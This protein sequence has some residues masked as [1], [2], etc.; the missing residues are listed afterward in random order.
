[1]FLA[2]CAAGCGGGTGA[3][4]SPPARAGGVLDASRVYHLVGSWPLRPGSKRT[5]RDD[6]WIDVSGGRWRIE[7]GDRQFTVSAVFDGHTGFTRMHLDGRG[8]VKGIGMADD[9]TRWHNLAGDSSPP[10]GVAM[11]LTPV[12]QSAIRGD[13]SIGDTRLE[14]VDTG[15]GYEIRI[16]D[17]VKQQMVVR[18]AASITPAEAD[19]R[20]LFALPASPAREEVTELRPGTRP[21]NDAPAF[22]LGPEFDGRKATRSAYTRM[23]A[24]ARGP[25]EGSYN[26]SYGELPTQWGDP[27]L[28]RMPIQVMTG[29]GEFAAPFAGDGPGHLIRLADGTRARL[30]TP[31][32]SWSTTLVLSNGKKPDRATPD[33]QWFTVLAHGAMIDVTGSFAKADIPRIARSLRAV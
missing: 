10:D 21:A 32:A 24:Q 18:V 26:I 11:P 13:H 15:N 1:M 30:Q 16:G 2:L 6:E 5:Y 20:N 33:I 22:W 7:Q 31:D 29:R 9:T 19:R 28:S 14:L 8:M 23:D 12:L 25:A 27:D 3:T 4:S 17:P